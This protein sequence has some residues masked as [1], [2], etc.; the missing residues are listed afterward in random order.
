MITT[1]V[2]FLT[3]RVVAVFITVF[4]VVAGVPSLIILI[5]DHTVT[6]T[7]GP[8]ASSSRQH[9]DDARTR[10]IIKIKG[11]GD[12]VIVKLSS[13]EATCDSQI[14]ALAKVSKISVAAT[15]A[16]IAKGKKQIHDAEAPFVKQIESDEEEA[17]KLKVI[18]TQTEQT[19]LVRITSVSVTALGEKG[20]TGVLVTVCQTVIIEI[21]QIIVTVIVQPGGGEG[22]DLQLH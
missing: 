15:Q 13:E 18:S 14:A 22:D 9:G 16:A 12:D 11:A 19:F 17:S 1:I 8:V 10:I 5:H 4:I 21:R 20:S 3:T 2:T 6:I 7:A